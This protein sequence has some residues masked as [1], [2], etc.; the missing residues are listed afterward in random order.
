MTKDNKNRVIKAL[1]R[2]VDNKYVQ[3]RLNV[4]DVVLIN[5][6]EFKCVGLRPFKFRPVLGYNY[7]TVTV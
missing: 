7:D 6:V 3:R 2:Y 1:R 5:K 4:G